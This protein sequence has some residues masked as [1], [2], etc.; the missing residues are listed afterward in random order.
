ME[1]LAAHFRHIEERIKDL[2]HAGVLFGYPEFVE[3]HA[4][5]ERYLEDA[6][7]VLRTPEPSEI[8][9]TIAALSMQRLPLEEF[10]G[11]SE[12]VLRYY[13]AGR[14]S[15]SVFTNAVF[16]SYD[17]NTTFAENFT[18]PSVQRLLN[19]VLASPAVGDPLKAFV[20][21]EILSG[22]GRQVVLDLRHAGEIR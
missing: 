5:P 7:G 4:Q 9:K 6:L 12:Q 2:T 14:V 22:N 15:E 17:W 21:D 8:Q 16:C 13:E 19:F 20:R 1:D 3:I 11:F 10:V 18:D